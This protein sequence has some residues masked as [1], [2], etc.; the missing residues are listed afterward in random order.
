MA[1][2]DYFKVVGEK[3]LEDSSEKRKNNIEML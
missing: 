3:W 2:K 1:K